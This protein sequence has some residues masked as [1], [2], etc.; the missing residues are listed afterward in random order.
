MKQLI[1][2]VAFLFNALILFAQVT[3][4]YD[5]AAPNAVHHEAIIS[6]TADGLNKKQ[7]AVFRMSRSSPG[8]YATHEFGKN[9]YDVK[10]FDKDGNGL[11]V[12]KIDADVYQISNHSGFVKL[13]YTLYGNHADGTYASIDATGLHLNIPASFMWLKGAEQT[14][15]SI[16]IQPNNSDF[17][18]ATQL[19]RKDGLAN[20]YTA[21]NLA[22][23]MDSPIKV[24]KLKWRDWQVKNT[25]GNSYTIRFAL[26]ADA[27]DDVVDK[28]Q[29]K[30]K[31][32]VQEAKAVFGE[33]PAF[34]YGTYTFI[35]S[36]N[37]YVKGD[38]ME[39]RNSTMICLPLPFAGQEFLLDVFAHEFFHCWNVERIRPKSIE[40]F[41]F[42]KSNMSDG[43]WLA[44]GFTQY[45]GDFIL[46]RAGILTLEEWCRSM[47]GLISIKSQTPGG[48]FYSPIENSQRAV[49]ADA[50]VSI[51]KTNYPNMYSSYYPYGAA[52]ALALD[53][54][55]RGRYKLSLDDFMQLLWRKH[56]KQ[57]RP[58]TIAD[59]QRILADLTNDK[60]YADRFFSNYIYGYQPFDYAS[61]LRNAG[62]N[63][64]KANAGKAWMG[65]LSFKPVNN[66]LVMANN[67]IKTTPLYDAGIDIDDVL[68]SLNARKIKDFKDIDETLATHKP[69]DTLQVVLRHRGQI[70]DSKMVLQENPAMR[71]GIAGDAETSEAAKQFRKDWLSTKIRF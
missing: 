30:L 38:G 15:I 54:D 51:D 47:E 52:I 61:A 57:E 14:P 66:E 26:E 10:A 36:I 37:P 68:V 42:E 9:V 63:F 62:L 59:L 44:E 53:L 64:Y 28:F 4:H 25:D 17:S 67:S 56:G 12:E 8:R 46:H 70:V 2:M 21:P 71:I 29:L 22:Y 23:F 58:Y 65:N 40:P 39:H 1:C 33:F 60:A 20:T 3:L 32:I 50:G 24:A 27:S 7:A 49:F 69:G 35:S 34:D 43:L 16:T 18:I 45:Y 31:D 55:L 11:P 19:P 41:N 48:L 13:T 5:V 6:L